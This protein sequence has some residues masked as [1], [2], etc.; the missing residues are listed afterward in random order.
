MPMAA[1]PTATPAPPAARLLTSSRT[2]SRSRCIKASNASSGV[3][4]AKRTKEVP[5]TSGFASG[6]YG[7]LNAEVDIQPRMLR[8]D[9]CSQEERMSC[10]SMS[11]LSRGEVT[12][13]GL[14]QTTA[15]LKRMHV[16]M[17][18]SRRPMV[19]DQC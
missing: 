17:S 8:K 13:R 3:P 2:S 7:S 1:P 4:S 12:V 6:V 5:W 18:L 10:E 16:T 15:T 19:T 9:E 11:V 14:T